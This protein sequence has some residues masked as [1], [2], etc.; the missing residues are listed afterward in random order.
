VG[1]PATTLLR[2][3]HYEVDEYGHVNHASYLH[4]LEVA[5][6]EALEGIGLPLAQMRRQDHLIVV[7]QIFV[8]YHAPAR[9]GDMLEITT[10]VREMSAARS[11]WDQ[12][13][14]EVTSG[15][16]VVTAEVT[17]AFVN[18]AGRPLRIPEAYRTR[19]GLLE[20][21]RPGSP[22]APSADRPA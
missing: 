9:A 13:I 21:P 1:Q 15:R 4:Y 12:E 18:E 19:L 16:L 20:R 2:A 17:G 22:Q 14:R 11:T 3:R 5:R 8:R 6:I 7:T 10:S